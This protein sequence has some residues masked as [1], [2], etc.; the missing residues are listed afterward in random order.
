MKNIRSLFKLPLSPDSVA[1]SD[2]EN[3]GQDDEESNSSSSFESYDL[4]PHPIHIAMPLPGPAASGGGGNRSNSSFVFAS[5]TSTSS[6]RASNSRFVIPPPPVDVIKYSAAY[7]ASDDGDNDARQGS[8]NQSCDERSADNNSDN[9]MIAALKSESSKPTSIRRKSKPSRPRS[10]SLGPISAG[11]LKNL[12]TRNSGVSAADSSATSSKSKKAL[13]RNSGGAP[14]YS[15]DRY[16]P[17][18]KK[19]GRPS[20]L[21]SLFNK[22]HV[23]HGSDAAAAAAAT[24]PIPS[25]DTTKEIALAP[26]N[27]ASIE[28]PTQ[29]ARESATDSTNHPKRKSTKG[30]KKGTKSSKKAGTTKGG[31]GTAKTDNIMTTDQLVVEG[32]LMG[33]EAS[34]I[35]SSTN[36]AGNARGVRQAP[37][38]QEKEELQKDLLYNKLEVVRLR[39]NLSEATDKAVKLS[40][41]QQKDRCQFAKDTAE[42]YQLRM[43]DH[44][45]SATEKR[46]L[47]EDL[48]QHIYYLVEKDKQIDSLTEAVNKDAAMKK[49]ITRLKKELKEMQNNK[50]D[51]KA[52]RALIKNEIENEMNQQLQELVDQNKALEEEL[53]LERSKQ[54]VSESS[55]KPL[56]KNKAIADLNDIITNLQNELEKA[57][58]KRKA[59]GEEATLVKKIENLEGNNRALNEQIR[60][61]FSEGNDI[62]KMQDERIA[63]L[64]SEIVTLKNGRDTGTSKLDRLL[65][66]ARNAKDEIAALQSLREEDKEIAAWQNDVIVELTSGNKMLEREI[67]DFMKQSKVKINEIADLRKEIDSGKSETISVASEN[68][69]NMKDEI[70]ALQSLREEDKEIA[71]WQSDVIV[72]LT[73]GNKT[74]KREIEDFM[75]QSKVKMKLKDDNAEFESM[76]AKVAGLK[77]KASF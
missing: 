54:P 16:P 64:E 72:E 11:K 7:A 46:R 14:S 63:S 6:T 51:D 33:S 40:E 45:K 49:K 1:L 8:E 25:T 71:A 44:V 19:Q 39:Q 13:R 36:A 18:S 58:K 23:R 34:D 66:N 27:D 73:S 4:N 42:L 47:Q 74:L 50:Q 62:M 55:E 26:H 65:E 59:T 35:L 30:G 17:S 9:E 53:E 68:E 32:Q 48:D 77:G 38:A 28:A 3:D 69:R 67:E 52:E 56:E 12:F 5:E 61:E 76:K 31:N 24:E 60:K 43:L 57:T 41:N 75:K 21:G 2:D 70:V 20:S 22:R 15:A 37:S 10:K 29:S